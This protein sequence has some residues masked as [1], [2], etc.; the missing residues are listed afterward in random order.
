VP[1][2]ITFYRTGQTFHSDA[3]WGRWVG[4]GR[5]RPRLTYHHASS[6]ILHFAKNA[7]LRHSGPYGCMDAGLD[8]R[9]YRGTFAGVVVASCWTFYRHLLFCATRHNLAR[10]HSHHA[11]TTT[12]APNITSTGGL[13]AALALRRV[14][15]LPTITDGDHR[16]HFAPPQNIHRLI[17]G[18]CAFT[19]PLTKRGTSVGRSLATLRHT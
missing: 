9:S 6:C 2:G 13:T 8:K 3:G 10:F 17:L 7:S 15:A 12:F 18:G 11:S 14:R 5:T 1:Y 16:H 19:Q 4:H